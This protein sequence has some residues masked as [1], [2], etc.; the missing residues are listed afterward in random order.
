MLKEGKPK[1]ALVGLLAK[2]FGSL[3]FLVC[4]QGDKHSDSAYALKVIN[5][6]LGACTHLG[7]LLAMCLL[8]LWAFI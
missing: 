7:N 3:C 5:I 4:S 6:C 2:A 8:M 1:M